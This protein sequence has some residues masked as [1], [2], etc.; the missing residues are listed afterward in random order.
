MPQYVVFLE[1][2]RRMGFMVDVDARGYGQPPERFADIAR[3]LVNAKVDL[4]V[5]A[6][7]AAIRAAQQATATIPILAVTDD[8]VG[9]R[10]VRSLVNP[11][12][13]TTGVSILATE[14]DGKRQELLIEM[15]PGLRRMGALVDSHTTAP[16]MLQALQ[17]A[18]RARG[19]EL[20]LYRVAKADDI[21]RAI[22]AAKNSGAAALNVLASPLLF[23]NGRVIFERAAALRVP[24]IYQW[25]EMAEDGGL[26]GYGPRV[27]QIFRE[28][29][30]RQAV[31]ILRGARPAD[32]PVEQPTKFELVINLKT[33]KALGL[34]IPQ[35]L[36]LRADRVIQ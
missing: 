17:G 28:T 27:V 18:A 4:I 9:S 36:L 25:P 15:V 2:L 19:V 8:M 30:T 29:L 16:R 21:V 7:D 12:G 23:A 20:S 14:L 5:C 10:L 6:G 22:D 31:K 3:E 26:V 11:G 13:N 34:T 35:T 24:A 32:L 33:A 1:E